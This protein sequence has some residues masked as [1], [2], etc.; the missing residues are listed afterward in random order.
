MKP[1]WRT[2][3]TWLVVVLV[4]ILLALATPRGVGTLGHLPPTVGKSLADKV[5]PDDVSDRPIVA[6]VSFQKQHREQVDGWVAGL[7][8][9]Q[10]KEIPWVRM[11][12]IDDPGDETQRLAIQQRI[13]A[14][15]QVDQELAR[16]MPV[17]T[18]RSAFMQ[19]T[20]VP[21]TEHAVVMVLNRNGDVL[22]RV[23]GTYDEDKAR[24]VRDALGLQDL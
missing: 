12:V 17:F 9:R 18:D 6:L 2:P 16:L 22:A 8:L 3:L 19:A 10:N 1:I 14:R 23:V 24:T 4:A 13:H 5:V 15:Y 11:P 21:T 7:A 20:G